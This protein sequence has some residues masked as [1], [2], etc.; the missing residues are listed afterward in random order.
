MTEKDDIIENTTSGR[1]PRRVRKNPDKDKYE[2][3]TIV[4]GVDELFDKRFV[5]MTLARIEAGEEAFELDDFIWH[6]VAKFYDKVL[7]LDEF[8]YHFFNNS[9]CLEIRNDDSFEYYIEGNAENKVLIKLSL[10]K[11]KKNLLKATNKNFLDT[12]SILEARVAAQNYNLSIVP[13]DEE[14]R[15][16]PYG[17]FIPMFRNDKEIHEDI[18]SKYA[19]LYTIEFEDGICYTKYDASLDASF[20]L[21]KQME[22]KFESWK[23]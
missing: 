3:D 23:K 17:I 4:D 16:K 14:N 8:V 18:R 11:Y 7:P 10:P 21:Y 2:Y 6:K 22:T 12:M 19:N 15:P 1:K 5:Q 9:Y 20:W 13:L